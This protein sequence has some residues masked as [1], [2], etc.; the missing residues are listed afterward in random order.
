MGLRRT[1]VQDGRPMFGCLAVQ[2]ENGLKMKKTENAQFSLIRCWTNFIFFPRHLYW[3]YYYKSLTCNQNTLHVWESVWGMVRSGRHHTLLSR[4]CPGKETSHTLLD[5][6]CPGKEPLKEITNSFWDA[7]SSQRGENALCCFT[8][9]SHLILETFLPYPPVTSSIL[10]H[11]L[12]KEVRTMIK[13]SHSVNWV[14]RQMLDPALVRDSALRQTAHLFFVVV[15]FSVTSSLQSSVGCCLSVVELNHPVGYICGYILRH[16]P[17][18]TSSGY[19]A[20]DM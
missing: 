13:S 19:S 17:F 12:N 2:K 20:D 11:H 4:R 16:R 14:A 15:V 9:K 8:S 1:E 18:V 10:T 6:R 5:C 7:N 3:H